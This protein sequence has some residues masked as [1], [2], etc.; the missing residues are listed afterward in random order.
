MDKEMTL[1][2]EKFGN[3]EDLSYKDDIS[4]FS[5]IGEYSQMQPFRVVSIRR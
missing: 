4:L 5:Q 3:I 2:S 1:A